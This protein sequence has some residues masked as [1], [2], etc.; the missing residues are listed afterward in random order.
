MDNCKKNIPSSIFILLPKSSLTNFI[1]LSNYGYEED[2]TTSLKYIMESLRLYRNLQ[3]VIKCFHK[4]QG[5][6]LLETV[7]R[8]IPLLLLQT[9]LFKL[10]QT[11]LP[12]SFLCSYDARI[13]PLAFGKEMCHCSHSG[14]Q[15]ALLASGEKKKKLVK[16][17]Q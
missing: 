4:I 15:Q 6:Y 9:W 2:F 3:S 7:K 17:V 10:I 13:Y 14:S 5:N 16:Q 12:P 8:G 11:I 1:L